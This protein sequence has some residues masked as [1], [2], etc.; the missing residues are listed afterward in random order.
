MVIKPSLRTL[1]LACLG[2]LQIASAFY[3][4][5]VAPQDYA[6][7]NNVPLYVN[8]LTPLSNQQV[9]S[10]ISYDYYYDRFHFC[11]PENGPQKQ[12]ESLGSVLFGDRIFTSPFQLSMAKN[13]TCKLLCHV[14]SIPKE[15]AAFINERI[16][17]NYAVNMVVDG[18]P[19]AHENLDKNTGEIY[20]N[21]GFDL[22]YVDGKT[23]SLNN[24]Y[25][26][27]IYYHERSSTKFRVIGVVVKPSSKTTQLDTKGQPICDKTNH[28]LYLKADGTDSVVYTYSTIWHP[29][30]TAWATRWDS[31][32]HILDPSI[33][34][35]SLVNSIVIVLFLTGMVAMI[36]LRALHKDISRYNAVEAQV[37]IRYR[38]VI[39]KRI[40]LEDVQEDYGWK[41]VHGDVFR[42]PSHPMLLAVAVGSG[43]QLIAMTA[44]TLVFA[45]LGFLSPSNRGS[46]ATVTVVFFMVFSCI[47]GFTSARLYK[48][49]GGEQWKLNIILNATL[50]PGIII[51]FLFGLNFFLIGSHS[52]G[53]VPFGTMMAILGLWAL[54]SLPL[55]TAG[56][57]YGLR[58]PRIE[59]PVRTN[60]I[61]RQIPDQPT[62]LRSLPSIFMGGILP[63]G[64]IFIE[65]YYIMN[66]I[67]FHR[68]Y[69]GIGFLFLVFGVLILTCSQVTIL[70]CYFHLCN[71]DYHWSWRAFL[72]SGAAGFYVFLYSILYYLTKL[73]INSITSTVLYF[74]YSTLISVLLTILTGSIG[75]LACLLFLRKIFGS[76][77]VD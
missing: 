64:A 13:E 8:S 46:L 38:A 15:D 2:S 70:M 1:G 63:F 54:I 21:I 65:L 52:S 14:K 29:S 42:P 66:S 41:L 57:Y 4:P 24:H 67:W 39:N 18:L 25:D 43:A 59:Q 58:K 55:S 35:F 49:N 71:E 5:G 76:I 68:I 74:G 12:S 23:P 45:I 44:L 27:N 37:N 9:K 33:H 62:Y 50:F 69:Y 48:M 31:Y 47:S 10:V 11:R 40:C 77:K 51:G 61:P 60:Q 3:L 56:S 16:I 7:G 30:S 6:P 34:W 28:G 72:T 22:G 73:D 20:Y 32:L 26:I 75:Y 17:D 53:A 19:A 36:L